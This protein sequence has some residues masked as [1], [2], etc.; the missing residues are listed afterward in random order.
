[1]GEESQASG[2]PFKAEFLLSVCA[3]LS[4]DRVASSETIQAKLDRV[5]LDAD[6]MGL[7]IVG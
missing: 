6:R 1:M 5:L 2:F 7:R 4:P 3:W